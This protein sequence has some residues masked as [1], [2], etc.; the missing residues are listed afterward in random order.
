[1]T[2]GNTMPDG[3]MG[4]NHNPRDLPRDMAERL[5]VAL[6][7]PTIPQA[8]KLVAQLDGT[9]SFFKIGLWLAFAEGVDHLIRDIIGAG[10]RVFLDAKFFDIGKTV[11]E[12]VA[13]AAER[14]VTFLTVHGDE[15]IIGSAVRGKRGSP[16]KIF[17]ITVLTSLGD[18]HL[19]D[20]GYRLTA[21][22]LVLLRSPECDQIW[23]RWYNR[24]GAG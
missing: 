17:S 6:D 16:M 23:L 19:Y 24:I 4:H 21:K 20:M 7:V 14:G 8:E 13:R 22:E 2:A 12:G 9:V 15:D 5:I 3:N 18:Q 1:M 10:K 11:E